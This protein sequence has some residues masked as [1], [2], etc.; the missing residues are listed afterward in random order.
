M[1]QNNEKN[2]ID[3]ILTWVEACLNSHPS[4]EMT[5]NPSDITYLT[6]SHILI[7]KSFKVVP[8]RD[9]YIKP[10]NSDQSD[11]STSPVA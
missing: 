4:T 1:H 10:M 2:Y 9:M 8:K 11:L 3:I 6:P 5:T 7:G